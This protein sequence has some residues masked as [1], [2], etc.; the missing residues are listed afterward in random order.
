MQLWD[1][2]IERC[3][4]LQRGPGRTYFAAILSPENVSGGSD[5]CF[6]LW[7]TKCPN[8]VKLGLC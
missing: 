8:M 2:G 4:L 6:V 5:F 7:R 1:L 3:K